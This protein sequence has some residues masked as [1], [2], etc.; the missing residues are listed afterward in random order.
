MKFPGGCPSLM[1]II[2]IA[3]DEVCGMQTG[4]TYRPGQMDAPTGFRSIAISAQSWQYGGSSSV[5]K[6]TVKQCLGRRRAAWYV[7]VDRDNAV[8]A[9]HH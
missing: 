5:T 1:N 9:T 3:A 7:N 4:L 8:A 6:H 2:R